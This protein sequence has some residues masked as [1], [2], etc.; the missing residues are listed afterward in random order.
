MK[1]NEEI[2][3][4]YSKKLIELKTIKG[5]ELEKLEDIRLWLLTELYIATR[6]WHKVEE[7]FI[8]YKL[9]TIID[10]IDILNNFNFEI[11]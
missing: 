4:S 10:M 2:I 9:E 8:R 3:S 7:E 5:K 1:T 11:K 6:V